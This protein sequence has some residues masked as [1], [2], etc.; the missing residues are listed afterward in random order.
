M[1]VLLG[2][3]WLYRDELEGVARGLY[4]RATGRPAAVRAAP[5]R[6]GP[7]GLR[8]AERKI[9][10]LAAGRAD[11]VVLTPDEAASLVRDGLQPEMRSQLDSLGVR[12]LEGR[13]GVSALIR[14]ARLPKEL[15]GPVAMAL[16]DQEPIDAEGPIRVAAPGLAE[17]EIDRFRFRDFPIPRDA[18]PK[19][20]GRAMG[21]SGAARAVPV[22]MPR[23]VTEL[24]V[25][26]GGLT[27]YGARSR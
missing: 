2:L 24:R 19:L 1:I 12:L 15:I 6:P 8:S 3:G 10:T 7:V 13:V 4:D 18:V 11:S 20:M 17:W 25:R 27:L 9:A 23:V 22:R 26:P 16:K 14:T 21:D 5:G